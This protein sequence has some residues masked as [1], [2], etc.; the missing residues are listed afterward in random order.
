MSPVPPA[1]SSTRSPG[2]TCAVAD[3]VA[4]PHPVDAERH[5]VVHQVVLAGDRREHLA[6][7]LL[8]VAGRHFA[9]AEMGGAG[10][11]VGSLM[12]AIIAS[13]MLTASRHD[14]VCTGGRTARCVVQAMRRRD[15]TPPDRRGLPGNAASPP[16]RQRSSMKTRLLLLAAALPAALLAAEPPMSPPPAQAPDQWRRP[17]AQPI[18]PCDVRRRATAVG[19]RAAR[20]AER[21]AGRGALRRSRQGRAVHDPAEGAGRLQGARATGIRRDER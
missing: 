8:L 5:Q 10:L 2:F 21:R 3:E 1:R 11:V 9:E 6:D 17:P 7:Q 19:R 14:R 16:A 20:A 12:R 18:R 4:L 15:G 13:T